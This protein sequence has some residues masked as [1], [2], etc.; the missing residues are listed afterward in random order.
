VSLLRQRILRPGEWLY[1]LPAVLCG[2][3]KLHCSVNVRRVRRGVRESF[4]WHCELHT[5]QRRG[6]PAR[7]WQDGVRALPC[8]E[9]LGCR[10]LLLQHVRRR[11]VHCGA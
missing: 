4:C 10:Q 3:L 8:G 5:L 2:L 6:L 7:G 1:H 9:L 11:Q